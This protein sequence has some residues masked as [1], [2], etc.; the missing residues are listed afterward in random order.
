MDNSISSNNYE[1]WQNSD[2][3]WFHSNEYEVN[4]Y[5]NKI[6]YFE[7]L[8][9]QPDFTTTLKKREAEESATQIITKNYLD[10]SAPFV[11]IKVA[12]SSELESGTYFVP[13][14]T[15]PEQFFRDI[16]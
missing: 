11:Q 3:W 9:S 12:L 6:D 10:P 7:K 14:T 8:T 16:R 4:V 15:D 5:K 2:A 1:R 13:A